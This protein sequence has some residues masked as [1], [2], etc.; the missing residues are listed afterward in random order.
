MCTATK[1]LAAGA[2][3]QKTH[4]AHSSATS[5]AGWNCAL[6]SRRDAKPHLEHDSLANAAAQV[7][8]L[9]AVSAAKENKF[10]LQQEESSS[11]PCIVLSAPNGTRLRRF[12]Q[13]TQQKPA[14][15]A[16]DLGTPGVS[17]HQ[18]PATCDQKAAKRS[19]SEDASSIQQQPD[20]P[21]Q[22]G[23]RSILTPSAKRECNSKYPSV[24]SQL[25][26]PTANKQR[27]D[28][29]PLEDLAGLNEL[30]RQSS[31]EEQEKGEIPA[32]EDC[33]ELQVALFA[34]LLYKGQQCASFW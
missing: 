8:P 16:V 9:P 27:G 26:F 25:Q 21:W 32:F 7:Q 31:W 12:G 17:S 6:A 15:R 23:N 13:P 30:T 4:G 11:A 29:K 2:E 18:L 1:D 28:S 3:E 24:Q 20:L 34:S 5:S 22:P 14:P 19:R 10:K 33:L